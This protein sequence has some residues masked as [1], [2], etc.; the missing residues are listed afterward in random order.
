[1][2]TEYQYLVFNCQNRRRDSRQ[3]ASET[4]KKPGPFKRPWWWYAFENTFTLVIRWSNEKLVCSR[5]QNIFQRSLEKKKPAYLVEKERHVYQVRLVDA[6]NTNN[7]ENEDEV[8]RRNRRKRRK[9]RK[10]RKPRT[11]F[12]RTL[13]LG[14]FV[15]E[16]QRQRE[17]TANM[18]RK[19]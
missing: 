18:H 3:R 19:V 6:P 10:K 14:L 15:F 17:K 5:S 9:A 4:S 16:K 1:M 8:S 13:K 11:I 12:N 2:S 7:F